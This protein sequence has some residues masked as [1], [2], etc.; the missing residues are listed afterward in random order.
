MVALTGLQVGAIAIAR[1]DLLQQFPTAHEQHRRELGRGASF[2]GARLGV[3]R[4]PLGATS[5]AHQV[6]DESLDR[7]R[8]TRRI[9]PPVDWSSPTVSRAD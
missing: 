5:G 6:L 9:A 4:P 2:M 3:L 1:R 8:H 7:G